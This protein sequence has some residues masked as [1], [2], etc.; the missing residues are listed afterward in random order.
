MDYGQRTTALNGTRILV[1]EDEYYLAT[2]LA[3]A[4][5]EAG[6]EVIGPIGTLPE[7]HAAVAKG[8][9]D[10]AVVDINLRGSFTY[11]VVEKLDD[12]GVPFVIASGYDRA[13]MPATLQHAPRV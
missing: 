1:V 3:S 13:T 2:D 7:A 10:C 5:K 8:G 6:A 4:L 9:F 11:T 12:L